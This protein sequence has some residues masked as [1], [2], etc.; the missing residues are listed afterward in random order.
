MLI[1]T[2]TALPLLPASQPMLRCLRW[3]RGYSVCDQALVRW[4]RVLRC[5]WP[6]LSGL[7]PKLR[8]LWLGLSVLVPGLRCIWP[9]HSALGSGVSLSVTRPQCAGSGRWFLALCCLWWGLSALVPGVALSVAGPQCA[10]SGGVV[11]MLKTQ[12]VRMK[13]RRRTER[14]S[15]FMSCIIVSHRYG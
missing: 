5:L 3:F 13:K 6:G 14:S 8:C 7:V 12:P 9:D 2:Q 4:S 15:G 10:G 1:Y 11:Q